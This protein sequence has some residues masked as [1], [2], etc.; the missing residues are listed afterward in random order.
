LDKSSVQDQVEIG[1]SVVVQ[2]GCRGCGIVVLRDGVREARQD[3]VKHEW[4]SYD[5][6]TYWDQ[7]QSRTSFES[8]HLLATGL[9]G[10]VC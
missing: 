1:G 3:T 6:S 9:L 8:V 2:G 5:V 10:V 4:L 7:R